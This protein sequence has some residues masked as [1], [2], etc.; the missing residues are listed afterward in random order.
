[1]FSFLPAILNTSNKIK[2]KENGGCEISYQCFI[3]AKPVYKYKYYGF[4]CNRHHFLDM[5]VLF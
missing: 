3:N 4:W 2:N 1:M 5:L